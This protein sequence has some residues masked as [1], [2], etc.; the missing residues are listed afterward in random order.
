[1]KILVVDDDVMVARSCS[2]ILA[3]HSFEVTTVAGADEALEAL[4]REEFD[5]L[6][7]DVLMPHRD[8]FSLLREVRRLHPALPAIVM[9]GYSTPDTIAGAFDCG[10]TRFI[11]KP[12]RPDELMKLIHRMT[13]DHPTVFPDLSTNQAGDSHNPN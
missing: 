5:L 1:M 8:G 11:A 10:A 7:L 13:G 3:S 4:G 12:F 6:L 2:R 9:S